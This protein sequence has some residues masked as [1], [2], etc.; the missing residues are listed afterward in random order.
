MWNFA[1]VPSRN[2]RKYQILER[3]KYYTYYFQI[4]L[5][6]KGIVY[7]RKKCFVICA[8]VP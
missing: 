5:N 7:K 3:K 1:V 6:P 2:F 8:K 4:N